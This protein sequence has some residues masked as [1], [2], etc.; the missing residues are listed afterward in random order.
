M[1][2]F[3]Y[4]VEIFCKSKKKCFELLRLRIVHSPGQAALREYAE[5]LLISEKKVM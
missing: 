4:Y 1:I 2:I 3:W 5:I